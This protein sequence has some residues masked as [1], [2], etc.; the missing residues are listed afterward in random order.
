MTNL[1][2]NAIKFT[3]SGRVDL[4]VASRAEGDGTWVEFVVTAL[5]AA[6]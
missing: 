5:S 4:R 6:G 3:E 1:V 2:K